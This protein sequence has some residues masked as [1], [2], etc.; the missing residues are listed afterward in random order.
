MYRWA[1]FVWALVCWTGHTA[2]AEAPWPLKSTA[3]LKA[4]HGPTFT[5][6]QI[7]TFRHTVDP[8]RPDTAPDTIIG[9]GSDFVFR[10]EGST[11]FVVD[12][13]LGRIYQVRDK[14]YVSSPMAASIV[15]W[16]SELG[17]RAALAKAAAAARLP[18]AAAFDP[19]WNAVEL[20]LTLPGDP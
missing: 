19:F 14:R 18:A 20:R 16:D 11:R 17:N 12:L 1:I 5:G 9:I 3:E 2:M 15:F 8:A 7:L 10:E 6:A 13:R 4:L